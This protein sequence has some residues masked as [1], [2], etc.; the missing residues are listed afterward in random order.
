MVIGCGNGWVERELFDLGIGK[1]FDAFDISEKYLEIARKE[2]GCRKINYFKADLDNLETFPIQ[3]YDA[4]FNVGVLHHGYRMSRMVWY[5]YRSLK[6]SGL[7]FNFDYVGP[8]RNNYQNEHFELLKKIND[9]L[10]KRFRSKYR[11]RPNKEDAAFG[12][13]TEAVNADLV[14]PTFERFFDIVYQNNINGGIG[15]PLLVNNIEEFQKN[16]DESQYHLGQILKND[17]KYTIENK[18]PVLF[19]YGI[20]TPKKKE[21]ILYHEFLPSSR[22]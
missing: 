4:I 13:Q 18:I 2:R 22:G 17:K 5:L 16:D 20:G 14:K 6:P 15:Y 3:K 8:A 9:E 12:D 11:L 19:W 10:P 7:M 1:S 21:N